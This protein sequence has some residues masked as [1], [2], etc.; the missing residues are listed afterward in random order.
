M[1]L[2][3]AN[4]KITAV[5]G[6]LNTLRTAGVINYDQLNILLPA[7]ISI[8]FKNETIETGAE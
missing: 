8:V 7:I 6:M 4:H 2:E 5:I 3:K 1:D